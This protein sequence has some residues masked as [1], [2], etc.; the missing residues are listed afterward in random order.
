MLRIVRDDFA[1]LQE[2]LNGY[3]IPSNLGAKA[4]EELLKRSHKCSLAALQIWAALEKQAANGTFGLG[5]INIPA[6]SPQY[7]QITECF[8]DLMSA[9]F[10]SLH[11]L[12]KPANMSLRSAIETFVRGAAG[13]T[14]KE[15][16]TTTSLYK[17]FSIAGKQDIFKIRGST[18]FSALNNLYS[19]LCQFAHSATPAHM[20]RTFA[21][22]SYPRHDTAQF[23]EVVK[24]SEE[25]CEHILSLLVAANHNLYL[26]VPPRAQDLLEE[27]IPA[28]VRLMALGK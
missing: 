4:R 20:A 11:G 6:E 27:V 19:D 23:K 28:E 10:S 16:L 8:S 14:S 12:Y 5:G 24:R 25:I 3:S 18:H 26:Q 13:C 22:A 17:L 9:L 15:A 21:L 2:Y 1:R 7:Q